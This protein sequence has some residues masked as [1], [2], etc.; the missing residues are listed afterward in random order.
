MKKS[1]LFVVGGFA[2]ALTFGSCSQPAPMDPAKMQA[3]VDSVVNARMTAV[4]DSMNMDCAKHMSTDV[5]TI[6][7]SICTA[8]GIKM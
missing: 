2:L 5:Q 8:N 4:M 3:K 1:M 6:C 7:D